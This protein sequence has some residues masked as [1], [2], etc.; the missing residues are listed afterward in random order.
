MKGSLYNHP[1]LVWLI[2]ILIILAGYN[3]FQS[4]PRLE[5]PHLVS[6]IVNITT[7]YPG[8]DASRVETE[9]TE[10]IEQKV[11]EVA[12]VKQVMTTSRPN[13]SVITVELKDEVDDA[14]PIT[15]KLRDKVSEVTDMPEGAL[16]PR[17][18]DRRM[19]AHSAIIALKWSSDTPINYA[20]LGRHAKEIALRLQMLEGTDFTE[21]TGLSKEEITIALDDGVLAAHGLTAQDVANRIRQS[22]ARSSAGQ[23]KSNKNS[24]VI[25]MDGALD[26]LERIRRIPLKLDPVGAS[27]RLGDAATVT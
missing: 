26:S 23:V 22:D 7:F 17:F 2:F 11:M 27:L 14:T 18:N 16:A 6:R 3:A 19:Y 20:I 24:Y 1:R 15:A 10:K 9:I 21:I 13:V 12:E 4:M 25:E 8:A 5:D